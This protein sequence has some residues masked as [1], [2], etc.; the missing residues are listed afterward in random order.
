MEKK[1]DDGALL[2]EELFIGHLWKRRRLWKKRN[3]QQTNLEYDLMMFLSTNPQDIMPPTTVKSVEYFSNVFERVTLSRSPF[4]IRRTVRDRFIIEAKVEFWSERSTIQL[5]YNVKFEAPL[6][7]MSLSEDHQI[8]Q[9]WNANWEIIWRLF[10]KFGKS[11]VFEKK[12][13]LSKR[14]H[15]VQAPVLLHNF[16]QTPD[17]IVMIVSMFCKEYSLQLPKYVI[18]LLIEFST[19]CLVHFNR[20]Q[21][22]VFKNCHGISAQVPGKCKQILISNCEDFKV[23]VEDVIKFVDVYDCERVEIITIGEVGVH[24]Y[25]ISKSS[26]IKVRFR[27]D[28]STVTFFNRSPKG[29][30]YAAT[31]SKGDDFVPFIRLKSIFSLPADASVARW[32]QGLGWQN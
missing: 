17:T 31:F 25:Q 14:L 21:A 1:K 10:R 8:Y 12:E 18:K 11:N 16:N 29:L 26:D 3:S 28:C 5:Q 13:S 20:H 22:V 9:N 4:T 6:S 2:G 24:T 19:P 30:N 27:N 15:S 23:Q 7:T 32:S